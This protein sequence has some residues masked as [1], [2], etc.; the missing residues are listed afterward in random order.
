MSL[1]KIKQTF[2]NLP[3]CTAWCLKLLNVREINGESA[4]NAHDI[5]VTTSEAIIQFT[6]EVAQ[7]YTK[8]KGRL[9]K[10]QMVCDYDGSAIENR[11]Y[12]IENSSELI[13]ESYSKLINA[14]DNADMKGNALEFSANA[15]VLR[16]NV[17]IDGT[18][19][20]IS[21]FTIINPFKVLK[22]TLAYDGDSFKVL[23]DKYLM[24]RGYVDVAIIDDTAY[25]FN[26]NGEKLFNMERAYRA[27]CSD[28]VEEIIVSG[29]VSDKD[30]F[31]QY[32]TSG[33]NPRKFVA[34]DEK[35]LQKIEND[36][37]FRKRMAEKFGIIQ[38]S[39]GLFDSSD[40]SNVNRIV[41]FLC[42]KGMIDP[43]NDNPV[44]VEG[45]RQWR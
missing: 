27:I 3:S 11:I 43:V 32:A 44:E 38:T 24:L 35:R 13:S 26:M 40:G 19:V 2:D 12:K 1:Q 33:H 37:S 8:E 7:T 42:K 14:M 39:E 16:G 20:S 17:L 29:V 21:L 25:L 45:A 10:Y 23:K 18:R 31:R 28:R 4:Y 5:T 6:E 36:G 34:F 9:S 30:M 22:H 15:Y 41:K